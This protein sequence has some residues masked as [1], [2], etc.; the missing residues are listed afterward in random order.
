MNIID[1]SLNWGQWQTLGI[2]SGTGG[3]KSKGPKC[4]DANI[5]KAEGDVYKG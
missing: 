1:L 4:I 3:K 2:T 5:W